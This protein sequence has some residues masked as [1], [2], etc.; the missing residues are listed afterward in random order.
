MLSTVNKYMVIWIS[1]EVLLSSNF[2]V[3]LIH[4]DV[5]CCID[6]EPVMLAT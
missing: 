5:S 2:N 3:V 4:E 1:E 6:K